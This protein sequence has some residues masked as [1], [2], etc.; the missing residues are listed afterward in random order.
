MKRAVS[1]ALRALQAGTLRS[2]LPRCVHVEP[3][4][5]EVWLCPCRDPRRQ[6]A[7]SHTARV[8]HD[9]RE[10]WCACPGY[11]WRDDC[12]HARSLGPG[13]TRLPP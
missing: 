6:G 2:Q 7:R 5:E 3:D 8:H 12:A 9:R 4:G 11:L 10:V 13:Y 1:R